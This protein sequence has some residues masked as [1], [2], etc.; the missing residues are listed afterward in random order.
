MRVINVIGL[1]GI[2]IVNGN[3]YNIHYRLGA[4]NVHDLKHSSY[5]LLTYYIIMYLYIVI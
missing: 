1:N 4:E 2:Y 3:C 5:G